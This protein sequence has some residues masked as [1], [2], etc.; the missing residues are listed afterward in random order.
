LWDHDASSVRLPCASTSNLS[1]SAVEEVLFVVY[2]EDCG[3]QF[4]DDN[5]RFEAHAM[6][7]RRT[8][9]RPALGAVNAPAGITGHGAERVIF[10]FG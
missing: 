2:Y 3:C 5:T 8:F 4:L 1:G 6:G 10:E 7:A 9:S